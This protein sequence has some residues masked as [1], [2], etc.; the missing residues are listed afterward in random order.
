M[1]LALTE[2][3][4]C[5]EILVPKVCPATILQFL[6]MLLANAILARGDRKDHLVLLDHLVDLELVVVMAN[7]A[8]MEP[9]ADLD[10]LVPLVA[11][12][13]LAV[14]VNLVEKEHPAKMAQLVRKAHPVN[15][16]E[17]AT[18]VVLA[19]LAT[20]VPT[21]SPAIPV[22]KVHLARP[23]NPEVPEEKAIL[24]HKVSVV[25]LVK[26]P[27]IARAHDEA[28]RLNKQSIDE[29]V[30]SLVSTVL[31]LLQFISPHTSV[32]RQDIKFPETCFM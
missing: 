21:A 20:P 10:R 2:S 18:P 19:Q 25:L 17:M 5:P 14:Q 26:T 15:P 4:A 12:D 9:M 31:V 13:N 27:N 7:L 29:L 23:V 8:E 24:V 28:P 16:V 1:N 30:S 32:V 3:L 6:S 11:V 22:H